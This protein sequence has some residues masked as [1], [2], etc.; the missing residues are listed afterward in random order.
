MDVIRQF[1]DLS[2]GW[3]IRCHKQEHKDVGGRKVLPSTD[4]AACHY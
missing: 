1:T 3:C 4:C 2:M